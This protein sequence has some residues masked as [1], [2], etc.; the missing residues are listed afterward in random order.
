M[1][2]LFVFINFQIQNMQLLQNMVLLFLMSILLSLILMDY[3]FSKIILNNLILKFLFKILIKPIMHI[4]Y[5]YN[6]INFLLNIHLIHILLYHIQQHISIYNY[7]QDDSYLL[8]Q[9][10]NF[11][12]Y[13]IIY[14]HLYFQIHYY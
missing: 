7:H 4:N 12:I 2:F 10:F 3:H 1:Y 6:F 14:H 11:Y 13:T 9:Q 5:V 8:N